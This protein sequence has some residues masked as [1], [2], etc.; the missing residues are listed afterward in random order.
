IPLVRSSDV[1]VDRSV[2][3]A[4]L[5]MEDDDFLICSFGFL[6]ATKYNDHLLK[7]FIESDL[8]DDSR[9]KLHFVGENNGGEYGENLL[10]LIEINGLKER[11]KITGFASREDFR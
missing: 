9:C 10:R 2:A 4:Q 7:A 11:V 3:R 6:D 5:K 8:F 1:D